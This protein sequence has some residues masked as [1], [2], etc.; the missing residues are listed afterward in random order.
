MA[1]LRFLSL[2]LGPWRVQLSLPLHAA[3]P[4]YDVLTV[5][6]EEFCRI[7]I[8]SAIW[9]PSLILPCRTLVRCFMH[10]WCILWT[11]V[12]RLKFKTA[13]L[14]LWWSVS[15]HQDGK[16]CVSS[17]KRSLTVRT[18]SWPPQRTIPNSFR[19]TPQRVADGDSL[20]RKYC[21]WILAFV[22]KFPK[23]PEKEKVPTIRT[24]LRRKR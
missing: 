24:E 14:F 7:E 19:K 6:E 13:S 23:K 1:K 17:P 11:V 9:N 12:L 21:R 8:C 10:F 20:S 22:L 5:F 18:A 4:D 15:N 16:T 3:L 2:S